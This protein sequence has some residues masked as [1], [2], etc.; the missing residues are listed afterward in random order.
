MAAEQSQLRL[1]AQKLGQLQDRMDWQGQITQR[2]VATLLSQ[3]NI[4]LA[5]AKAQ[6]LLREEVKSDLLQTLEMHV[7]VILGHLNELE[8]RCVSR[9]VGHAYVRPILGRCSPCFWSSETP[10]PIVT[11]AATSIIYAGLHIESKGLY[12]SLV[13]SECMHG[14]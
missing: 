1:T 14:N 12:L 8:R 4:A 9:G 2:D 10:S 6:K 7:G 5:R 3:G 13:D 11:E